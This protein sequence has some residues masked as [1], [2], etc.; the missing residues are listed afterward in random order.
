MRM[1]NVVKC[2]LSGRKSRK[3]QHKTVHLALITI[4]KPTT[5]PWRYLRGVTGR[6][7]MEA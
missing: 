4:S 7:E 2:G 1:E 6:K 3:F 5:P